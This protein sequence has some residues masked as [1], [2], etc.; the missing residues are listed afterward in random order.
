MIRVSVA[1]ICIALPLLELAVL[2]K[3]GQWLGLWTT[4]ALVLGALAIGALIL[5]R[6]SLTVMQEALSAAQDGR[7][8]VAAVIDGSFLMMAGLLLIF[9]GL[10]TDLLALVL[11]I[12]FLRRAVARWSVKQLFS[13]AD[14]SMHGA[15][16]GSGLRPDGQGPIIEGEFER[17]GE[18][19]ADPQRRKDRQRP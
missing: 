14:F 9:P 16:F 2:V 13:G 17:L 11:L 19:T 5:S 1:L 8:P 18:K 12:P 3:T 7:A 10:I 15:G 6:Q 4:V